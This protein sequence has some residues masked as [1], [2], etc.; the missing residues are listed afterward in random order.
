MFPRHLR[1]PRSGI[2]Y[3]R[4][5]PAPPSHPAHPT[6]QHAK[7]KS[8]Y[9]LHMR[10]KHDVFAIHL[11]QKDSTCR[12]CVVVFLRKQDAAIYAKLLENHK[13]VRGEWP[14]RQSETPEIEL[15]ISDRL[16]KDRRLEELYLAEWSEE[17]VQD[18]G[19]HMLANMLVFHELKVSQKQ[20]VNIEMWAS[21]V[22]SEVSSGKLT[23]RYQE[24]YDSI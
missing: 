1:P 3:I 15:T 23:Q 19:V 6:Q 20:G 4:L 16:E 14:I 13:K 11:D 9:T 12:T 22:E 2:E 24:I 17:E 5:H 21:L 7:K 8:V 18:L 10:E